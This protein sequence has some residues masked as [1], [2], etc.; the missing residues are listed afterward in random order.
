MSTI[1]ELKRDARVVGIAW[2]DVQNLAD[3]LQE[4]DRET[5][6]RDRE[7][8]QLAWQVRCGGSRGCWGFWRHGFAKRDGRRYEQGDQT[9]I[10][11]Y[12]IIHE[13]VAAE[14]PE[15]SGDGG[16]DRLFEFLFHPCERLLTRRQALADALTELNNTA[17]PVPF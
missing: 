10:P 9:A 13:R 4:I 6:G 17:E 5:K 16:E 11:R 8:R 3:Y 1:D 7:I 12:D 14:F 2:R 15:Y